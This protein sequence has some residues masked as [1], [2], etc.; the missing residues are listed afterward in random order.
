MAGL[1]PKTRINLAKAEILLL[2]ET[3]EGLA[4]LTQIVTAFGVRNLRRCRTAE[5][6]RREAM[7]QP[8]DL[9]LIG[10]NGEDS[11]GHDFIR[12]LRRSGLDPNAFTPTIL[13]SGHTQVRN[14]ERAR[15]CGA[16]FIVA[17]PLSPEV[18][19]DRILW[20]ARERR[21]FISCAAYVGPERRFHDSGPP[22]G[23]DDRRQPEP[24]CEPAS[25]TAQ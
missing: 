8:L 23:M 9:I 4:V 18:L 25:G 10:S 19:L 14:V 2:E 24:A 22:N 20:V 13:I 12:W 3:H 7:E 16:N 17:K 5:D 11:S 6:A 15:D 21:P 1:N